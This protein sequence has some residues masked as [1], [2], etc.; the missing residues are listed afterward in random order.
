MGK[1]PLR[2]ADHRHA[3]A[4]RVAFA[5]TPAESVVAIDSA[6]RAAG[7]VVFPLSTAAAVYV[8]ST[9]ALL[10]H[11]SQIG[12]VPRAY[13]FFVIRPYAAATTSRLTPRSST[14]RAGALRGL[15][16]VLV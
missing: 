4:E 3:S 2:P 11:L 5:A 12:W 9:S 8:T 16:L 7:A 6:A 10:A 1:G 13:F 14:P 15:Q